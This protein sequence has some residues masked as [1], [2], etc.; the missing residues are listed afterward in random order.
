MRQSERKE[1]GKFR[2][3]LRQ[4]SWS[5][6]TPNKQQG[7]CKT[8]RHTELNLKDATRRCGSHF[9]LS[10]IR[11]RPLKASEPFQPDGD[12][13]GIDMES[14]T[15]S[16]IHRRGNCNGNCLS[17]EFPRT[18]SEVTSSSVAFGPLCHVHGRKCTVQCLWDGRDGGPKDRVCSCV[19]MWTSGTCNGSIQNTTSPG[20]STARG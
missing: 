19:T 13:G 6:A 7:S 11:E 18:R 3:H 5:K 9:H 8:R 10:H 17:A 15:S 2:Q 1:Q 16:R 4:K 14:A 12:R 20:F